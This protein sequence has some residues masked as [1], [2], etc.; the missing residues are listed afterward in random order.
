MHLPRNYSSD[1]IDLPYVFYCEN[2]F[3]TL[4]LAHELL[5]RDYDSVGTIRQNRRGKK[6]PLK[7]VK[8]LSKENRVA[9][10]GAKAKFKDKFLL[11]GG[12]T[13]HFLH[14][15]RVYTALNLLEQKKDGAKQKEST[16]T[17]TLLLL[18]ANTTKTRVE[19]I[20]WIRT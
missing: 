19:L 14:C 17:L 16:F 12:K 7:D 4:P 11:L 15:L 5:Q 2:L 3:T 13:M 20:A 6:G 1:K 8:T 9:Y 10:D 18:C